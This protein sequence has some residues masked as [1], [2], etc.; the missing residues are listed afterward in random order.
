MDAQGLRDG[1]PVAG[2]ADTRFIAP[3]ALLN[4]NDWLASET[5]FSV[6]YSVETL[7]LEQPGN[8][9]DAFY[10][11]AGVFDPGTDVYLSEDEVLD[12]LSQTAFDESLQAQPEF[13]RAE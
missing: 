9:S 7:G 13:L 4:G 1:D 11:I 10:F 12:L 2:E 8:C 3:L 6:Y 5:R